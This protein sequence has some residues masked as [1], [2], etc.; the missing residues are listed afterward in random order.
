MNIDFAENLKVFH[1]GTVAVDFFFALSGFLISYLAFSEI[2]QTGKINY[3]FFYIRRAL[4]IMPLYYLT[5]TVTLILIA[6]IVP[7]LLNES[8]LGF[9]LF[10]GALL[11]IVMLP[12][13]VKPLWDSTVGGINIL[14]SIGV[15]EQF[16]LVFPLIMFCLKK[17]KSKLIIA[18]FIYL[19]YLAFYWAVQYGF[20]TS[21]E[22]LIKFLGTLKFHFMLMG[23]FFSLFAH[24]HL[25]N[26]DLKS[27]YYNLINN[28]IVQIV[29]FTLALLILFIDFNIASIFKD[30]FSSLV[31]SLLILIVSH[32]TKGSV[33]N[34]NIKFLS[35]F[36]VIS[37]GIY[38][39][40]PLVSYGLRMAV[41]KIGFLNSLVQSFPIVY[42]LLLLV[43]TLYVSK[44]SYRYFETKFLNLKD[45]F[46]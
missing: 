21:N 24:K 32:R 26:S 27:F 13:L 39:L 46:R 14:W 6:F 33:F 20:I 37:Y 12:N 3:R 38:L 44:L 34:L 36:G 5:L 11:F 1:R 9:P 43:L 2:K 25:E 28:N 29:I 23:I 10:E 42:I 35:Y 7:L 17:A 19:G 41:V 45:R 16:Y 22:V 4:R 31:F 15:E 40:H 8:K 18:L 30:I